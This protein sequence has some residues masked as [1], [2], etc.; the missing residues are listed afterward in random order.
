MLDTWFSSQL[1]PF[2]TMGWTEYGTEAPELK[3][4]YPTQVLATARDIMGTNGWPT[5]SPASGEYYCTTSPSRT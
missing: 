2:A 1:W 5:W 3:R 4:A